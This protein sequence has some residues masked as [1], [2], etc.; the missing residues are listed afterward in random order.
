MGPTAAGKTDFAISIAQRFGGELISVDSALV[1]RGLDIGAAKPDY[2]HHLID[3]RD[4]AEPYSA[5]D[6]ARDAEQTIKDVRRR[7]RLPILVGGTMLYYRAL[8]QGLD[9]IPASDPDLR[10]D[11]EREALELGWPAMHSQLSHVD[12]VLA[13]RLHPNHSQRIGRGLEVFRMTGK[14]LSD[15]Q[16]GMAEPMVKGPVIALAVCPQERRVLHQR[17]EQRFDQMLALGLVDEVRRLFNRGDLSPDLP[18]LRAVGYRQLWSFLQGDINLEHARDQGIAATRQLAKRQ[19]TWLR[20][21]PGLYWLLTD[22]RGG[23]VAIEPGAAAEQSVAIGS[24]NWSALIGSIASRVPT[25][26]NLAEDDEL[27]GF[28]SQYLGNSIDFQTS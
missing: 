7:G 12:P 22:S 16:Q 5:M 3:I 8:L 13:A 9:D 4:P 14:P 15:W 26:A 10:A 27:M 23:L 21:W 25:D 17:I 28:L 11:I 18:A 24:D 2:P 20:R 19:L 6:F 1:Y